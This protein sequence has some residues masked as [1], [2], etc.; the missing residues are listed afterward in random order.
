MTPLSPDV[1]PQQ[2]SPRGVPRYRYAEYLESGLFSRKP[3]PTTSAKQV[4][5]NRT[6]QDSLMNERQAPRPIWPPCQHRVEKS[7]TVLSCFLIHV[8]VNKKHHAIAEPNRGM[9]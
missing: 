6:T 7:I 2:G 5:W 8:R 1:A 4:D 9:H 3:E